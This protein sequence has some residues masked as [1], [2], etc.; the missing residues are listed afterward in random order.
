M[1]KVLRRFLMLGFCL[2]VAPRPAA[3]QE[4]VYTVPGVVNDGALGTFFTCSAFDDQSVTVTVLNATGK[5]A[6]TATLSVSANNS[7]TFGTTSADGISSDA[8]T[9]SP[10]ITKGRGQVSST[11]TKLTCSATVADLSS[12]PPVSVTNLPVLKVTSSEGH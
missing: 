1:G 10:R 8:N 9:G 11:S 4:V 6:G 7:V 12:Q 3:A 5:A 2:I